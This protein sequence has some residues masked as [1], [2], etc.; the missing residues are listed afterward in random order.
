MIQWVYTNRG[1]SLN[2]NILVACHSV[3]SPIESD[4]L[5]SIHVGK[6]CIG[7]FCDEEFQCRLSDNTKDNISA[8]NKYYAELTAHYWAWKNLDCEYKGVFHYRRFL[9]FKDQL[10]NNF[11]YVDTAMDQTISKLGLERENI[12]KVLNEND[13]ILPKK[14]D[15]GSYNIYENYKTFHY[16]KDIILMMKTILDFDPSLYQLLNEIMYSHHKMYCCNMFVARKEI[17]DNCVEWIFKI[18]FEIEKNVN[19]EDYKD[20]QSRVFGFLG[21]RLVNIYFENFIRTQKP[22]FKELPIVKVQEAK[23]L[24]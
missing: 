6:S 16:E 7:S 10:P 13:L 18:L 4:I 8:K 23:S 22:K 24:C 1:R 19:L 12:E 3:K 21:E 9:D 17:F 15:F 11:E 14:T 20:E 2:K 5:N